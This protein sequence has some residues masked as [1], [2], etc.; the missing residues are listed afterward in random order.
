MPTTIPVSSSSTAVRWQ[1]SLSLARVSVSQLV[2]SSILD[3][4]EDALRLRQES[5]CQQETNPKLSP[6]TTASSTSS[7]A[8][9]CITMSQISENANAHNA[10]TEHGNGGA[11]IPEAGYSIEVVS[12]GNSSV[13]MASNPGFT[14]ENL[15]G[16]YQPPEYDVEDG[17]RTPPRGV[18]GYDDDIP[19]VEDLTA[20]FRRRDETATFRLSD[21]NRALYE[22]A[23]D[24]FKSKIR[25]S[26]ELTITEMKKTRFH[27]DWIHDL[28][29]DRLKLLRT[30]LNPNSDENT[31]TSLWV[32][33]D[34]VAL[35][36]GIPGLISSGFIN[37]NHFGPSA[38]RRSLAR[39]CTNNSKHLEDKDKTWRNAADALLERYY[40]ATGSFEIAKRYKIVCVIVFGYEV[41][42]Y[43]VN[44]LNE[45]EY[46]V[47]EKCSKTST[48]SVEMFTLQICL[49]GMYVS[50]LATPWSPSQRRSKHA[51]I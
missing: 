2:N 7:G 49:F 3:H 42:I 44:I 1:G 10:V 41:S 8:V 37:E 30:G 21:V 18:H 28:L 24:W 11:F 50:N 48:M 5:K 17:T 51:I 14:P 15:I 13:A 47:P 39:G 20:T 35:Q 32:V 26:T 45:N 34:F 12:H 23:R 27:Q 4:T 9:S 29:Y 22:E 46:L 25:T 38:W 36:T 31:Y 43:T 6:S 19:L 40:I 33:P 16:N